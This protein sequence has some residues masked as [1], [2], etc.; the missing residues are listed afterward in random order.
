MPLHFIHETFAY[1]LIYV[2]SQTKRTTNKTFLKQLFDW[3]NLAKQI[4]IKIKLLL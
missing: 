3:R 2:K 4:L 1:S